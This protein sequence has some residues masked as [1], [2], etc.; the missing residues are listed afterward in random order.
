MSS[1]R[2][3]SK[4]LSAALACLLLWSPLVA[5]F[6]R[7]HDDDGGGESADSAANQH[8]EK[9]K[10]S[11]VSLYSGAEAARP[12]EAE[13]V[14][15]EPAGPTQEPAQDDVTQLA[16]P[17]G[18]SKTAVT[19]QSVALPA[20][21]GS[22]KGMGESFSP[23]LS[24]GTGT[25]S[26]P[27]ALP[28]GRHG[29]Q[30]SLA[31]SYATSAGNGPLGIG[32]SLAVP[33][34][35]RQSDKGMP[36]YVDAPSYHRRE[37]RFMYNGGQEL[38]PISS[39][40]AETREGA[41]IPAELRG[42]QQYRS[43]VE[44]AFMRFFRSPDA[45][46]WVVQ[47]K[48]GTRFD[49]GAMPA[50]LGPQLGTAEDDGTQAD[51][52]D[53][54]R[55]VA[56]HLVRMSD[57]HGSS[58]HYRYRHDSGQIYIEDIVY[59]S[60]HSCA[61]WMA[62]ELARDCEAPLAAYAHHVRFVYESRSD[63]TSNYA[64]G[65]RI[66]TALRL[67]RVE[68][69][70]S[71][72][73]VGERTLVRRYH[74]SYDP[75]SFHSLLASVQVEG[76][77]SRWDHQLEV[78]VG[79]TSVS[80][81]ELD[82][83][84]VGELLPPMQFGY[85]APA[86]T[87]DSVPGFGGIDA[88]VL[89]SSASPEHSV[90]EARTDLFDVNGD[91]LPD[92]LVTLSGEVK[93]YFNGFAEGGAGRAGDFSQ[94]VPIGVPDGLTGS[95]NLGS[96]NVLPMDVDGD[97]RSDIL[98][99]PR[100]RNYG[101]FVLSKEPT[102]TARGYDPIRGWSFAHVT[103]LLPAG[104]TD[105]RIDLGSDSETI[106]TFD[107]NTDGLIDVVRTSGQRMQTWLNLGRHDGGEG[108]FGSARWQ[109]DRFVLSTEPLESCL[110][111]D[112]RNLDFA[113]AHVRIADMNG[114]GLQ[115]IARVDRDRIVYW[116]NR[117]PGVWG[118][119]PRE[120]TDENR[121]SRH[122]TMAD[123][124]RNLNVDLAGVHLVDVNADGAADLVQLA[125]D[126]LSVWFN[127]LGKGFAPRLVVTNTPRYTSVL[128]RVRV[129]D[130]DGSGT[131][132]LI[133]AD[134]NAYK[135]IDPM[136]GVR[137]RLLQT[138][139]NGLG[140]LTTLTYG[141]SAEDYLRDLANSRYCDPADLDCFTWQ[142]EP[143]VSGETSAGCDSWVE[144][145]GGGCVHRSTGSPVVSTV[146]RSVRTS[147][148]LHLLG[149][150]EQASETEYAYHD[151]YYEGIEQEFRGF[152]AADAIA[153]G[154]E[155]EPT[156]IT[157]T[158]FHQG[159]RPNEM[160]ADRLA[161]NPN[162]A[163]KGRE[164]LTE[165]FDTSGKYLSTSHGS[166]TV[167]RLFEGENG[168]AV[169][170]AFVNASDELRYDTVGAQEPW[171]TLT[172]P[173]VTRELP[174]DGLTTVY[175]Q[176]EEPGD[177]AHVLTIRS[178]GYARIRTTIDEVDHLG[179]VL[180]QTQ[181]GRGGRGEF[182]ESVAD[183]S[184]VSYSVP[185][186]VDDRM[187][188]GSGWVF[189]TQATRTR[190]HGD[191]GLDLGAT[192]T[193]FNP[194]GDAEYVQQTA[195][196]PTAFNF[197]GDGEALGFVQSHSSVDSSV[198]VDAWGQ[199][200]SQC[201]GADLFVGGEDAC[202]R[203][204]KLRYDAAYGQLVVEESS[205]ADGRGVA[206]R[207]L[208]TRGTWDPGLGLLTSAEDPNG[209]VSEMV[210]DGLGR[211]TASVAPPVS[212][213]ENTRV[214]TVRIAYELTG[215]A[216]KTPLS[217]VITTR[218]LSCTTP[219]HADAQL[220]SMAYVDGFGRSRVALQEGDS[221]VNAWDDGRAH[222]WTASGRTRLTKRG[223]AW[224]SYQTAYYDGDP[225]D[226]GR[227]LAFPLVPAQRAMFDAFSRPLVSINEDGT[228]R[229]HSYHALS[230]D[231]CDEVDN[232]FGEPGSAD[233]RGSCTTERSD[234]H[235]RSI[236]QELRQVTLDGTK[237]I[238][239]LFMYYRADG[240]VLRIVRAKTPPNTLRPEGAITGVPFVERRFYYD[241]LGRR[242]GSED[243]DTDDRAQPSLARRTWRYLFNRV[244]DLV[245]VR[246][247]RGCGQNFAYD[248]AGRLIGEQYVSCPE[249]QR[250]ES[251]TFDLPASSV[252]AGFT[253][254]PTPV[255]VRY[256]FDDIPAWAA[257]IAPEESLA[258]LGRPTGAEDRAMRGAI[259]T[260]PR[261]NPVWAA[262][263]VAV[264]ADE[265]P[266]TGTAELDGRPAFSSAGESAVAAASTS[267]DEVH[268]YVRTA[269]YDHAGRTLKTTLPTD[270]DFALTPGERAPVIQGTLAFN[271][272]GAPRAASLL[273]DG[274]SRPVVS[275]ITYTRDGLVARTRHGDPR[276][277]TSTS[278][279]DMRR[280]PIELQ[281]T[282]VPAA[283]AAPSTLSAVSV[284][285]S[286]RLSWDGAQNL[287]QVEDRRVAAQWPDGHKPIAVQRVFHDA[288]Y[289]VARVEHD[290]ATAT[291][292]DAATDW[293]A[294]EERHRPYDPMRPK[295]APMVSQQGSERI[296]VLEYRHDWLAN[297]TSW[298][299]TP[300]VFY[301]RAVGTIANGNDLATGTTPAR[302]PAALYL[303]NNL[304]TA[305]PGQG[306][307]LETDF[308][309]GGNMLAMTV[310]GQCTS[311][312]ASSCADPGGSD[313]E[314]RRAALRASCACAFEQH[315]VYRW[316]ELNRLHEARRYDRAAQGPWQLAARQRYR[317]DS[318]NQR[319]V[320]QSFD[321]TNNTQRSALYV[322]PGDFERRGLE[323]NAEG[324]E[325]TAHDDAETQYVVAGARVV[326]QTRTRLTGVIDPDQR[327]TFSITNLIQST[328]AVVDLMTGELVEAGGFY[329]NGAREEWRSA[330]DAL[331]GHSVPL[332]P[333]GFTGKES[334]EE[335][336]VTYFGYR[337]L[338]GRIGRWASPDPLSVH[339]MRGGEAGNSFHY[340]SG[341]L[342][343]T[344]D[345]LGLE[346]EDGM[347]GHLLLPDGSSAECSGSQCANYAAQKWRDAGAAYELGD[348]VGAIA[349]MPAQRLRQLEERIGTL[350]RQ[351]AN[352]EL[353]N[354]FKTAQSLTP[355]GMTEERAVELVSGLAEQGKQLYE[356][357]KQANS[358][359]LY[360]SSFAHGRL[361]GKVMLAVAAAAGAAALKTAGAGAGAPRSGAQ[362]A[363]SQ[364]RPPG[365]MGA[366]QIGTLERGQ[367]THVGG[368]VYESSAGLK[369][370]PGSKEG[371][372]ILHVMTHL[373]PDP[374]KKS[375]GVFASGRKG[376]L[377][378]IDEA[379]AQRGAPH[380]NDPA[381]YEVYMGRDVGTEG[382]RYMRVVVDPKTNGVVSAYPIAAP[383]Y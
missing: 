301:E 226:F 334:D 344:H 204:S 361:F 200:L 363:A 148:R 355:H 241:T 252:F 66:D 379:W 6:A 156:S 258:S 267:F 235:G 365:N 81:D 299:A 256:Y 268:T 195:Q 310:H 38:V 369:Y 367:L 34:I 194:C 175:P 158:H 312:P 366:A 47:S 224:L 279:Y 300:D 193:R 32:W 137:P 127:R 26:V 97:G 357:A 231:L 36:D 219:N 263:Q 88:T 49:F 262:K 284:V 225:D 314:A 216:E 220:V 261:G 221:D 243:P 371:H 3:S 143:R 89:R 92:L 107:V 75:G 138:V 60:P 146:V 125:D 328:S 341:S 211:V 136:G 70:S 356:L 353:I 264:I 174:G 382:E 319:T 240:S 63:V 145:R 18:P 115:D 288:L 113:E 338:V 217:R 376:F 248:R 287:Y 73:N 9:L 16:L 120:C 7:A 282:R 239:R 152:G 209:F 254:A 82:D 323:P 142:K 133:F 188:G 326:W 190:G 359:N 318:A 180:Q 130:I 154:D 94:A 255:H 101:Y 304:A 59:T 187:C 128:D 276:Q 95:L 358:D 364:R 205:I 186:R 87:T 281:T 182:G 298:R 83:A 17:S 54:R 244:G 230:A 162:E 348:Q 370:G 42:W 52:S 104:V 1:A 56:W 249:S 373:T 333:A 2:Y 74:L 208:I 303:A 343:Q 259:A 11:E 246:D 121:R 291:R 126:D 178:H 295:A 123:A 297:M 335:V 339:A 215:N 85:T 294:E 30:P 176:A 129:A 131:T 242:V 352:G 58:V 164:Y 8:R 192:V 24:S 245:A 270:P 199:P 229:T 53:A 132:D 329:P 212:G 184:I 302:R 114:D 271:R 170:Y 306:G 103:N 280:R 163:L 55:I 179:H 86:S 12:D 172:L 22:I 21:E 181:H 305:P 337:Y 285:V 228:Y 35:Q 196:V 71:N 350:H 236:D 183:E 116:A 160:A 151:G 340:V 68:V 197:D 90:D 64:A 362:A 78:W 325:W 80:E 109:A 31:L 112:G 206:A 218:L 169:S 41:P 372:R 173:S 351:L 185:V 27:I 381:R 155:H 37:D 260:D 108:R 210:Y 14:E 144:E 214:P 198:Q 374:N 347:G 368:K 191:G 134:A 77:P 46:R 72:G 96:P 360:I 308:G 91:G 65:H 346:G 293:R 93:A 117:G 28:P 238:H 165:V 141:T 140:A 383:S 76:R 251:A 292:S 237:E 161:D 5:P 315:Y 250:G 213:C 377:A 269:S 166:Y 79:D 321:P 227:V 273:V 266:L 62:P 43:R 201:G 286:Q 330:G 336:G 202:F 309:R 171:G 159:R 10:Q 332:E 354:A 20:A 223:Q 4:L 51:P 69:T 157:R 207:D 139:D 324:D 102:R 40:L 122:V 23:N 378:D 119:G 189:R 84:I 345:P 253:S 380:P 150:E 247:P 265:V 349:E 99:M 153:I 149:A 327:V 222:L 290:Y 233:Y 289:R 105:P 67:K 44:G 342:L 57:V 316:D 257:G 375:H 320:K 296:K 278:L 232:G 39:R 272:A 33:F 98:H 147:D 274:V 19:P 124:P 111:F 203:L 25:F 331:S 311:A 48:D 50:G 13:P 110:L 106:K 135:W 307:W 45:T 313:L 118:E 168:V 234:G 167:R 177:A 29:V 322:Y 283:G 15:A 317:Y 100:S 277:T 275:N 61:V